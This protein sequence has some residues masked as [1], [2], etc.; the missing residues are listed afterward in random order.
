M[1][2]GEI[3]LDRSN[4]IPLYR[5]L[6]EHIKA[7]V[8]AGELSEGAKLP[9]IRALA[10]TLKVSPITITQAY[11]LLA[12]EGVTGGQVGRGT[13][14]LAQASTFQASNSAL[15]PLI[16]EESPAYNSA[17]SW[18]QELT[19]HLKPTRVAEFSRLTQAAMSRWNGPAADFIS[20]TSGSPAPELFPRSRFSRAMEQAG[21]SLEN[22]D[23]SLLQYGP[24]LGDPVTRTW[25]A[26]YLTRFEIQANPADIMLTTG[27]Q[28][29]IDLIA[30]VF[31]GPGEPVL[32]ESPSYT[33]ALDILEQ[34]GISWLPVPL[35]KDGLQ[36][37]QLSRLA[38]RYHP[39]LLY[40]VPTA[41]SPTGQTLAP[42]RRRRLLELARRYNFLII[43]D[44]T[45][46]E[47]YYEDNRPP[48]ALKSYDTDGHVLYVKSFSKQIFPTV[49]LG[50]IVAAPFLLEKLAEAKQ[51]F[52]RATSLPLARTVMKYASSPG[53]ERDLKSICSTYRTRRNA[54]L[55]A[56]EKE[57]SGTGA[58][59]THPDAG[60]SL[61]LT[62]PRSLNSAEVH[63]AAAA[64]GLGVQPGPVFYPSASDG[65]GMLRLTFC[66]NSPARLEEAARRLG[67]TLRELHNRRPS[68]ARLVSV[69]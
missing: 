66:D 64:R 67:Q 43:E 68:P 26:N 57:L 20:L 16:R 25:L 49:R 10:A 33:A 18:Q 62:L 27:S 31:L 46:N 41:Q 17:A 8:A 60:F 55:A 7:A 69:V 24:P 21:Q 32:V 40:C 1:N 35:D 28:Q 48:A 19:S 36:I 47:F 52:D 37:E 53:F 3:V 11:D 63:Q 50:A 59:W 13:F 5:Q 65:V 15:I 14:I 39:K 34:R 2:F 51:V 23:D 58:S 22:E 12:V 29:G 30:R 61:L 9:P 54:F 38:E 6:V 42:E 56:L 44:D 4:N 45:C